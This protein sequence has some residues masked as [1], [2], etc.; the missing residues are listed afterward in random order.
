MLAPPKFQKLLSFITGSVHTVSGILDFSLRS[1]GW[2][3]VIGWQAGIASTA[4]I[5]GTL[6]QGLIELVNTGYAPKLWHGTLLFYAA[7]L[8]SVFIDTVIG[9]TLPGIESAMLVLYILGFFGILVPLVYLGP[10]ST[11]KQVFTTFLNDGN[12][13]SQGLSFFIGLSGYAFAFLG[14]F[15]ITRRDFP[16]C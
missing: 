14:K 12:W 11:A 15:S 5:S 1:L 7:L 10:H 16:D 6:I 13:S 3:T 2:L 8:L 9:T 4:F